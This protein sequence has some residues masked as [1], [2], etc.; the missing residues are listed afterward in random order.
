MPV[1]CRLTRCLCCHAHLARVPVRPV[2]FCC[3]SL[4]A[5]DPH[6]SPLQMLVANEKFDGIFL[7]LFPDMG[8][9]EGSM[10]CIIRNQLP[11]A[12]RNRITLMI[13]PSYTVQKLYA[14][15][16]R[17]LDIVEGFKIVLEVRK[18]G[19]EKNDIEP[20]SNMVRASFC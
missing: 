14:D 20:N 3:V 12:A 16:R 19:S 15:I 9:E 8:L 18:K 7:H 4:P 2:G 17:Q 5:I 10:Q 13:R 1:L 11:G 6:R